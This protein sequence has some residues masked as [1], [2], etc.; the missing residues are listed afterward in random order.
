MIKQNFLHLFVLIAIL[1]ISTLL[2]SCNTAQSQEFGSSADQTASAEAT[3]D[4]RSPDPS[5]NNT[6]S[7]FMPPFSTSLP[8]TPQQMTSAPENTFVYV[9]GTHTGEIARLQL[10]SK[11][12]KE[13]V[14]ISPAGQP[15]H[16]HKNSIADEEKISSLVAFLNTL[17]FERFEAPNAEFWL[18]TGGS[19]DMSFYCEDGSTIELN[20][21]FGYYECSEFGEGK[22]YTLVEGS[23][24]IEDFILQELQINIWVDGN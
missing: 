21:I 16:D 2:V 8:D 17:T 5:L 12:I 1:V 20:N 11:E 19:Y 14:I 13:V 4:H 3:A 24:L 7:P 23:H 9:P 10:P 6:G 22:R 15:F 18:M